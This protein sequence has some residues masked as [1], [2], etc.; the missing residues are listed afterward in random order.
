M[1]VFVDESGDPG[2]KL[3]KGSSALFIVT[4]VLFEDRDEALACDQKIDHIRKEL[5]LTEKTE[6]HFNQSR[7]SVREYFL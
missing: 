2:M 1:L 6:F 3:D 5:G 4:A 7:K